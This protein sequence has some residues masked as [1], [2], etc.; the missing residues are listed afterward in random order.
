MKKAV[1]IIL[2]VIFLALIVTTTGCSRKTP[3]LTDSFALKQD[4]CIGAAAWGMSKDEVKKLLGSQNTLS[5][6][7]AFEE[8]DS[9]MIEEISFLE[10]R[11]AAI[12]LFTKTETEGS[13]E[14]LSGITVIFP[15]EPDK[16]ALAGK[17]SAVLGEIETTGVQLSGNKYDLAEENRF[18]HS[19][20]SVWEALTEAG[21]QTAFA[22]L[23]ESMKEVRE[24][25]RAYAEWWFS[26]KYLTTARFEETP[27]FEGLCLSL[28]GEGYLMV[29]KLNNLP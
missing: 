23:A 13:Q 21:K 3:E 29:R 12:F 16:T 18:W 2:A 19:K 14:Q 26:Q 27:R 11:A 8:A 7:S 24:I 15:D 28:S 5:D 6:Y 4:A 17:V 1:S 20:E 9:V 22:A 10:K 25:D